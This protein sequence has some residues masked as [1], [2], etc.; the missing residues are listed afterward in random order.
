MSNHGRTSLLVVSIIQGKVVP[1]SSQY[2]TGLFFPLSLV[3]E[4]RSK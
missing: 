2:Y 1:K 3:Q 4:K